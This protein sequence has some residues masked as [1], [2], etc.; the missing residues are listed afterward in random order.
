MEALLGFPLDAW[1]YATFVASRPRNPAPMMAI[2]AVNIMGWLG[3]LGVVPWVQAFIWAL[4]R[5]NVIDTRNLPWSPRRPI[6]H[7]R[8]TGSVQPERYEARRSGRSCRRISGPPR[9]AWMRQR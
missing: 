1:N 8:N 6:W 7:T 4:E 3:F 5:I 9:R 2:E